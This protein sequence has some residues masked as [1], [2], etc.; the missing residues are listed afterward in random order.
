MCVCVCKSK[1]H[2]RC[3]EAT[4]LYSTE[5]IWAAAFASVTL[6]EAFG[7]NT[8]VGGA[9]IIAACISSSARP[10]RLLVQVRSRTTTMRRAKKGYLKGGPEP[11]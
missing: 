8:I 1:A 9:L 5:P 10:K 6:G 7:L 3:S 4:A 11:L 2:A